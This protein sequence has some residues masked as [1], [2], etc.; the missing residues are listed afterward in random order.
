[1]QTLNNYWTFSSYKFIIV[2]SQLNRVFTNK[3]RHTSVSAIYNIITTIA[4]NMYT[5]KIVPPNL[6]DHL[7]N[8]LHNGQKLLQQRN[9]QDKM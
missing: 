8:L 6:A 7:A 4:E 3:N 5:A 1:M 2:V 9:S